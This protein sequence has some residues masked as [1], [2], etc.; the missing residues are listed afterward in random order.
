MPFDPNN[1]IVKQCLRAMAVESADAAQA[2]RIALE[3]WEEATD[4][5]ERFLAAYHAARFQEHHAERIRWLETSL[6]C[7]IRSDDLSARTALAAIHARLAEAY[8]ERGDGEHAAKHRALAESVAQSVPQ[9]PGPFFH[10]TR[11]DLRG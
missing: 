8:N 9:D 2:R 10:G 6:E 4:D 11:A 1:P 7:A 5:F 3:A